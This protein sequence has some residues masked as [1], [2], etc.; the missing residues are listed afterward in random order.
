MAS[1]NGNGRVTPK[2]P[3]ARTIR[4]ILATVATYTPTLG[5]FADMEDA[6]GKRQSAFFDPDAGGLSATGILAL[7][8]LL[9]HKERPD[10]TFSDARAL[11]ADVL[12]PVIEAQEEP[13]H[14]G[15]D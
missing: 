7:A 9:V 6:T 3:K 12:Q 15:A 8:W 1:T 11:P 10:F 5:D 14:A 4:D 13:A 2:K